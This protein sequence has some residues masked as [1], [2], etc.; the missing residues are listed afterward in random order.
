MFDPK[1]LDTSIE[2]TYY[3]GV[4][5]TTVEQFDFICQ[6]HPS[7]TVITDAEVALADHNQEVVVYNTMYACKNYEDDTHITFNEI[8]KPPIWN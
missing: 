4:L 5:V 8:Y 1:Y 7:I 3:H 6:H 2:I